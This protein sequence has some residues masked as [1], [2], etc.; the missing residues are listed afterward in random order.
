MKK[1]GFERVVAVIFLFL[2]LFQMPLGL[3]R[4]FSGKLAHFGEFTLFT[5]G[6]IALFCLIVLMFDSISLTYFSRFKTGLILT[7]GVLLL[8]IVGL[9]QYSI[10]RRFEFNEFM[11]GLSWLLIPLFC[12]VYYR[13]L[14][15]LLP[16]FITLL[17]AVTIIQSLRFFP[18]FPYGI[19]GNWNWNATLILASIPF[20]WFVT[21]QYF[22]KY[23]I[24]IKVI[25]AIGLFAYLWAGAV[26]FIRCNSKAS[27]I[28][29]V[30]GVVLCLF[31][32]V[33]RRLSSKNR[34]I[35]AGVCS[36]LA[37]GS[38]V[39]I[40]LLFAQNGFLDN[41]V[42]MY[43]WRG[44]LEL[45]KKHPLL[46]V[47][48]HHFES[49]IAPLVSEKYYLL[50]FCTD[51]NPHPHNN[52]MYVA[53]TV[54]IP[55]LIVW[56]SFLAYAFIKNV[57]IILNHFN[58]LTVCCLVGFIVIMSHAMVDVII[59]SWPLNYI[60][61]AIFGVLL[62]RAIYSNR[63]LIDLKFSIKPQL[64]YVVAVILSGVLI[65]SLSY[66]AISSWYYRKALIANDG[67]M[68]KTALQNCRKSIAARP[69]VQNLYL[70]ALL[71]FYDFK[72]P[73]DALRYIEYMNKELGIEGYVNSNGLAAR[74]L[75]VM[76]RPEE[77]LP[78]F[79]KEALNF[80][81]S[82][83]N[84]Y[85]YWYTLRLMKRNIEAGVVKSQ[86]DRALHLKGFKAKDIPEIIKDPSLDLN[87][88]RVKKAEKAKQS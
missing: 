30:I 44:S 81:L 85:F 72:S 52:F 55:A 76:H 12:A 80:P 73:E 63:K 8:C 21:W 61:M 38:A 79:K 71:A 40:A 66:N 62:G 27:F 15:E 64:G 18:D 6:I 88:L 77:A 35:F 43:I 16:G 14:S 83:V 50:K 7:G 34:I 82:I 10:L 53:A 54:G 68:K 75:V 86:L 67:G 51:R 5:P 60:F 20:A 41:D 2:A 49:G 57:K 70:A 25:A 17:G 26:V 37:L 39:L 46:G 1:T 58:M 4:I 47:G 3:V 84:Y 22:Q 33:S 11:F 59:V 13:A 42:R 29:M 48:A 23:K 31:F 36:V 24:V 56:I 45:I 32:I 74:S 87:Y 9:L 78:Y 65:Y 28:S 69:T 19:C